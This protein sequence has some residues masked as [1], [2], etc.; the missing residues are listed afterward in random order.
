MVNNMG[1]TTWYYFAVY[2]YL[3]FQYNG[4]F[5]FGILSLWFHFQKS[6]N[7]SVNTNLATLCGRLLFVSLF[8]TYFLSTLWAKPGIWYN[9]I[10]LSGALIQCAA[11]IYFIVMLKHQKISP[12]TSWLWAFSLTSFGFKIFLQLLS[13]HPYIAQLALETRSFVIAYLHLSAIGVVLASLLAW[14]ISTG[15][16]QIKYK[17]GIFLLLIGYIGSE[18][19]LVLSGI[20]PVPYTPLYLF[21][22]SAITFASFIMLVRQ[23]GHEHK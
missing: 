7:V 22:L 5:I 1:H 8:P 21:L 20:M 9:I 4:F 19:L 12:R 16:I 18:L 17:I 2:Y 6:Q 3:H 15:I 10:G 11:F 23:I 13:S 14:C